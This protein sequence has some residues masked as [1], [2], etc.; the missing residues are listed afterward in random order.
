M[1]FVVTVTLSNNDVWL[2]L[3]DAS[4][5]I[6]A[7]GPFRDLPASL[8]STRP[9]SSNRTTAMTFEALLAETLDPIEHCPGCAC[10]ECALDEEW[11]NTDPHKGRPEAYSLDEAAAYYEHGPGG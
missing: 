3:D 9:T 6:Y 2:N 1:D 4:V 11:L 10:A 8:A 7:C 5:R